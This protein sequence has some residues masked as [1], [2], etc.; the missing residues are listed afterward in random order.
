MRF[1][2]LQLLRLAAAVGVVAYHLGVHGAGL[3]TTLS[4]TMDW[5]RSGPWALFPVPVFF[6]LSGFVLTHALQ[7]APRGRFLFSRVLRLYPGYWLAILLGLAIVRYAVWPPDQA[8][9]A[10]FSATAFTLAPTGA[11]KGYYVLGGVEW[12]LIYEV[13][14]SIALTV[15]SFLGVRRGLLV[16]VSLWLVVLA[17]KVAFWPRYA[18]DP[19]PHW[20][21]IALSAYNLPFLLGVLVYF[22]RETGRRW[23]WPVLAGLA[24]I[25]IYALPEFGGNPELFWCGWGVVSAGVVWFAVQVKQ[26]NAANPFARFGDYTYGLYLVHV[27]LLLAIYYRSVMRQWD[28]APPQLAALAGTVAVVGGLLFGKLEST[29]HSRLRPLAKMNWVNVAGQF[30]LRL[31]LTPRY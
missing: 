4:P 23:R 9:W 16:G 7:S 20:S 22:L 15:L 27:P 19:F 12:S 25:A 8:I 21:T 6:A 31:R 26:V 1:H 18:S 30:R 29:L 24:A 3:S 5:L 10:K 11:G 17:A 28:I 2:N 13:F 14:L